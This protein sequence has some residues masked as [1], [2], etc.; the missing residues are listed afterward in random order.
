V[1]EPAASRRIECGARSSRCTCC[2]ATA[3]TWCAKE[4]RHDRR[5]HRPA[6]WRARSVR[7]ACT[8]LSPRRKAAR[9]RPAASRWGR[10]SIRCSSRRYRSSRH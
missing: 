8:T 1:A 10:C 9:R 3:T 5:H 2:S 7:T 6:G 4:G